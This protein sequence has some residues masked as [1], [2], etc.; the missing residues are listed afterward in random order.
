MAQ[1]NLIYNN[2]KKFLQTDPYADDLTLRSFSGRMFIINSHPSVSSEV[3][4]VKDVEGN[5]V[6]I[7]NNLGET[8]FS[9]SQINGRIDVSGVTSLQD[10][11]NVTG[12]AHFLNILEVDKD[13]L[14]NSGLTVEKITTL[15]DKLNVSGHTNIG[16]S[17]EVLSST[18]L[19]D[20]LDV[21]GD[22][23][24]HSE[25]NVEKDTALLGDLGVSGNTKF[26]GEFDVLENTSL[27]SNLDVF[28][29]TS[30]HSNLSVDL[31]ATL[32]SN[33][34]V[35]GSEVVSDKLNVSGYT[36]LGDS[37]EV[38]GNIKDLG[39]LEVGQGT[40]LKSTLNVSGHTKIGDEL[41]VLG[42]IKGS[43]NLEVQGSSI[44]SGALNVSGATS[45]AET[46]HVLKKAT[47]EDDLSVT[48]NLDVSGKSTF[49]DTASGYFDINSQFK[50]DGVSTQSNVNAANLNMLTNG[51]VADT[52]HRHKNTADFVVDE[53]TDL[54]TAYEAASDG[55]T[56]Y[57]MSDQTTSVQRI[58]N[59]KIEITFKPNIK[60]TCSSSL[61]SS[62][63]QFG[64]EIIT[65]NFQLVLDQT[66]TTYAG[67]SFNGNL[68]YHQNLKVIMNNSG[69]TLT[70]AYVINSGTKGNYAKGAAYQ[71]VGTVDI[72]LLDNSGN[73]TNDIE[74][75]AFS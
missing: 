34:S 33:L 48:K 6:A 25:L 18:E 57:V 54:W 9:N 65:K 19:K 36:K 3:F 45:L 14:A 64:D 52:L 13:I 62:V 2:G 4:R 24:L 8:I 71:K 53:S 68:S 16:N 30:L 23:T 28:G 73:V 10:K 31:D 49:K 56:I 69:G 42:K 66:G 1:K 11:L 67:I 7:I 5:T 59:K 44:L 21:L 22:V 37:L 27:Q 50:I 55:N 20:S 75:R 40:L 70:N 39:S 32:K 17:L 47:F 58:L 61:G 41:E 72:A 15:K 26:G 35:S 12:Y 43:S 74:I 60:V 51:S 29:D 38:L 46:L 63:I